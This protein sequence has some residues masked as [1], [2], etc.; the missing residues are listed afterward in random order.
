[1]SEEWSPDTASKSVLR[2]TSA[3]S[4]PPET[5]ATH[6][7]DVRPRKS[8]PSPQGE[9]LTDPRSELEKLCSIAVLICRPEQHPEKQ[10]RWD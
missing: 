5:P 10:Q 3:Q 7:A 1:V 4:S 6:N 8:N 9:E 2:A